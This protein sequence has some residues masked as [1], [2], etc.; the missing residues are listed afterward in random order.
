MGQHAE[1]KAAEDEPA[2]YE[3]TQYGAVDYEAAV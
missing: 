2:Y 3:A 1:Y